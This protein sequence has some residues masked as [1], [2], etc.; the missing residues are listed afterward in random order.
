MNTG[1]NYA[2]L[3]F[4]NVPNDVDTLENNVKEYPFSSLAR[5]L[6]LYHYKKNNNVGFDN[7]ARQT[8]I[9]IN[10]PFWIQYQLSKINEGS[11]SNEGSFPSEIQNKNVEETIPGEAEESDP[12]V[13]QQII[14]IPVAENEVINED[15]KNNNSFEEEKHNEY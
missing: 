7:F 8:G 6:L 5:F 14:Q 13:D 11:F 3:F 12:S 1:T 9:Y 15:E 2:D 4:S 10:N